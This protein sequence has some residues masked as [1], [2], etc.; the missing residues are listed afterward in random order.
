MAPAWDTALFRLIH[1]GLRH[2][3]LDPVMKALTDPGR[4]TIP[5]F[6]LAAVIM[7]TRRRRGLIALIVLA[8]TVTASDQ[9]SS[10]VLKPIFHRPRPSVELA[11]TRP[12]FGVRHSYSL[13][14]SHATNFFAAAPV[15]SALFPSGLGA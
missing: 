3:A 2:P 13:P 15:V 9:L 14:S 5:L 6:S 4:W 12:L 10:K 1:H 11:D 8:L 7:L